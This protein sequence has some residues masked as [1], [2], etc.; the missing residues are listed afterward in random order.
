M[1]KHK[2]KWTIFTFICYVILI[3]L[4]FKIVFDITP[5]SATVQSFLNENSCSLSATE[6]NSD[7]EYPCA[8]YLRRHTATIF[9]QII[10]AGF[11]LYATNPF[12]Y[13]DY[14][15]T[16]NEFGCALTNSCNEDEHTYVFVVTRDKGPLV[17]NPVNGKY[18]GS[19]N[20]LM[21][22]KGCDFQIN[23]NRIF[24]S[25]SNKGK[26]GAESVICDI[27]K[28]TKMVEELELKQKLK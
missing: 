21:L 2:F 19:Y 25:Q 11:P 1:N 26:L 14:D 17:Y 23:G 4:C 27:E 13:F 6:T 22:N 16:P 12:G 5:T 20:A 3:F 15:P 10:N 28:T 24:S 18:I 7:E 9:G 8:H